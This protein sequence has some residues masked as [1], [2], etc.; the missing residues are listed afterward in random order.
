MAS[1]KGLLEADIKEKFIIP[2]ILRSGCDGQVQI[3]PEEEQNEIINS[4]KQAVLKEA[5]EG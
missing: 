4:E 3:L 2:A 1:K 5:F